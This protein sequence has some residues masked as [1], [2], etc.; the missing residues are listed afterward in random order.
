MRPG[1]SAPREITRSFVR[2]QNRYGATSVV[3][4]NIETFKMK[5]TI[6][7]ET[8]E[9]LGSIL[10][11][12]PFAVR[13]VTMAGQFDSQ[14]SVAIV[15]TE[16]FEYVYSSMV[17]VQEP[18]LDISM[19]IWRTNVPIAAIPDSQVPPLATQS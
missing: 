17:V 2:I 7:E 3:G 15:S 14:L 4:T 18:L 5:L 19:T 8:I 1:G 6:G 13:C 16:R 11:K 10:V 9:S 12:I